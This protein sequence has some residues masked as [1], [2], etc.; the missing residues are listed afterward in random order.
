MSIMP[1]FSQSLLPR[2]ARAVG[3]LRAS[4]SDE[5]AAAARAAEVAKILCLPRVV[6]CPG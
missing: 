1:I 3:A 6:G 5:T 4:S 2:V